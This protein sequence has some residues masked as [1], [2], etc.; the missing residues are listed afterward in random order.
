[1]NPEVVRD[2]LSR[3]RRRAFAAYADRSR[4][5]LFVV[6]RCKD[7]IGLREWLTR[8]WG[9]FP[10][11]AVIVDVTTSLQD[12]ADRE[13]LELPVRPSSRRAGEAEPR[14]LYLITPDDPR[15]QRE[16]AP[17]FTS[18]TAVASITFTPGPDRRPLKVDW[19]DDLAKA[20]A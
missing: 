18:R 19:R 9:Y 1:M 14:T 3:M 8:R 15:I 11:G 17:G 6:L 10:G 20:I 12:L 4:D 13:D 5:P 16:P 7:D 2:L